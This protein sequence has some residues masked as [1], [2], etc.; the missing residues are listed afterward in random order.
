VLKRE[1]CGADA[2]AEIDRTEFGMGHG[3]PEA[4]PT[5]KVTL[6]IQVEAIKDAPGVS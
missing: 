2:S 5:G 6:E 4:V 1:L 3:V